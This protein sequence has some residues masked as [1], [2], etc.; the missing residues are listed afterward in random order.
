MKMEITKLGIEMNLYRISI[1]IL[2]LVIAV[3]GYI[4]CKSRKHEA[5]FTHQGLTNSN[6]NSTHRQPPD[7]APDS[8]RPT[9]VLPAIPNL[10][11]L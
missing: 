6:G 3:L 7:G 8:I 10:Y 5:Q 9:G 2:L 11:R 1:A 4:I